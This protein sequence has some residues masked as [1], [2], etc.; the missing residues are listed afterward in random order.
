MKLIPPNAYIATVG[1]TG[2]GEHIVKAAL[3]ADFGEVETFAH[4]RAAREFC[5]D[6]SCV[7]DIGG[8]DMKCFYVNKGNIGQ[9]IFKRSLLCWLWFFHSKL[10]S[11]LKYG[12][13][14]F[15]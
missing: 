4:L 1:T 2:Y 6:V 13:Q 15:C 5:P 7:L 11:R 12:S 9:I 10:R 14:R 3:H 8:Q